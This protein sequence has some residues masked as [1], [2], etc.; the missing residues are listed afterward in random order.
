MTQDGITPPGKPVAMIGLMGAGKSAVGRR[1]AA[2]LNLDFLDA[3]QEIEKAAGCSIS[4]IFA[5]FG[6]QSFREGERRV[7]RRIIEDN[8]PHVLATGGGAFMDPDTRSLLK[9]RAITIWLKAPLE[10]LVARTARRDTRPL[11]RDGDPGEILA[12]LME[13]RYPIYAEADLTVETGGTSADETAERV[14]AAL[15]SWLEGKS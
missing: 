9:Q 13:T 7:I 2:R 5:A 3:D 11:L 4:D 8:G 12:R 6:E 1:L 10:I 15:T 14:I